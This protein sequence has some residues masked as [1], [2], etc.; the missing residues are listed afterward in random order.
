[1][2][3][4]KIIRTSL[5]FILVALC[6]FSFAGNDDLKIGVVDFRTCI[7]KSY[8]GQAEQQ[9]LEAMRNEMVI[10]LES[11]EKQLTAVLD[12]L[13]KPEYLDTLSP[14]A[15]EDLQKEY[16]ALSE[17]IQVYQ[18]QAYQALNQAQMKMFQSIN[19]QIAKSAEYLAREHHLDLVLNQETCFYFKRPLEMTQ[20]VIQEL[21]RHF[22][23]EVATT[24][25]THAGEAK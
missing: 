15:E 5:A 10:S 24:N 3:L 8:L 21:N 2:E 18:N 23:P 11:K 22:Q 1:M 25:A 9:K 14:K 20:L 19:E 13:K 17:E 12:K 7:E 16:A 6:A 4:K